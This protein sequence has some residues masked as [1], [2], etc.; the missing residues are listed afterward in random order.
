MSEPLNI[1][2]YHAG[3]G[4]D[5][6]PAPIPPIQGGALYAAPPEPSPSSL[7]LSRFWAMIA[8][9]W[10]TIGAVAG[11]FLIPSAIYVQ[12][13]EPVYRS[14][15]LFQISTDA[16][17]VLPYNN[18]LDPADDTTR[19]YELSMKTYD[20]ILKSQTLRARVV[21]K[22]EGSEAAAGVEDLE[23]ALRGAPS[24][25]RVEG[26]QLVSLSYESENPAFAAAAANAWVEELIAAES[27][28][29]RQKV[30]EATSFLR[31]QLDH[32]RTEVERAEADLI[33]YSRR[34]AMLDLENEGE[35]VVRRRLAQLTDELAE[36]ERE[37]F[38]SEARRGS[39]AS[40]KGAPVSRL[41]DK[42][43]ADLE[44]RAFR[45]E[46]ELTKL[47]SQFG[48]EWPAVKQA[49]K[50][51]ELIQDQLRRAQSSAMEQLTAESDVALTAAL[52]EY[53]ALKA[54]VDKQAGLVTQLSERLIEYNSL[55]REFQMTSELYRS[56]LQ[57]L[58]ETTVVAGL[59]RRRVRLVDP[60][61]PSEEPHRPRKALTMLLALL[62]GLGFG[63]VLSVA[64]ESMGD[65][66]GGSDDV[67]RLGVPVLGSVQELNAKTDDDRV[68]GLNLSA[69][70]IEGPPPAEN[71]PTKLSDGQL[72][73]RESYRSVCWSLMLSRGDAPPKAI[74]VS[75]AAPKEGKTT[76]ASAI[77][78]TFAELGSKTLIVD[79]DLR[80]PR[81]SRSMN[82]GSG[83]GLSTYLSGG[84]LKIRRTSQENLYFLPSGPTPPN[85]VAL[86]T[87]ERMR[88]LIEEAGKE[89][90]FIVIDSPP[91][92]GLAD[93]TAL[94][95]YVD[96]VIL[97]TRAGKTPGPM[98]DRAVTHLKRAGAN[99]LGVVLNRVDQRDLSAYG[100]G[101]GYGRKPYGSNAAGD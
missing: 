52:K 75:S 77:G 15:A 2:P 51:L 92:L 98:L 36:A 82:A 39:L 64:A 17:K 49:E 87:S 91:L 78:A 7:D 81:L 101:Y 70:A 12:T 1:Q 14:T 27:E 63:V 29:Q 33:D 99:I 69:P 54:S 6:A 72:Y 46:Q 58:K 34:H 62:S 61:S 37:L 26:S 40:A 84:A 31:S 53:N 8:R 22:L 67:E 66:V 35:S 60:A 28:R 18:P 88:K 43:V 3:R 19:D 50:E 21:R 25:E 68:L 24:I 56:L 96:G 90:R 47:R 23:K 71:V 73:A 42:L 10:K 57:R 13:A 79:A 85:P 93:A 80:D 74:L 97:T 9:R 16:S 45:A 11:V 4:D 48:P 20:G 76:T 30:E 38:A 5:R 94:A 89:F 59:E 55:D 100:Y 44:V 65:T 41:N 86:F 32:L 95:S 83:E